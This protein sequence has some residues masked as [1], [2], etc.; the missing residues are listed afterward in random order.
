MKTAAGLALMVL[1]VSVGVL[2]AKE[3]VATSP[4]TPSV[5]FADSPSHIMGTNVVVEVEEPVSTR[6]ST[7]GQIKS[8][9]R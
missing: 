6:L 3:A 5:Y 8:L 9:Y 1:T 7:W 4:V 2:G